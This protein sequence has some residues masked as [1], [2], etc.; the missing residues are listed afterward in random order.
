MEYLLH[1]GRYASCVHAGR[2]SCIKNVNTRCVKPYL[3][4]IVTI[5]HTFIENFTQNLEFDIFNGI[6]FDIQCQLFLN[7]YVTGTIPRTYW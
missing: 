4:P 1:G 6:T 3:P 5:S 2:L 7:L